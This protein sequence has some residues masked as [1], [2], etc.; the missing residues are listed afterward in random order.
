MLFQLLLSSHPEEVVHEGQ[1][2]DLATRRVD[3]A[4]DGRHDLMKDVRRHELLRHGVVAVICIGFR[5]ADVQGPDAPH[6]LG[7]DS[8]RRHLRRPL[9]RVNLG[10]LGGDDETRGAVELVVRHLGIPCSELIHDIVV[11]VHPERVEQQQ[12]DVQ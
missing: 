12:A 10:D 2:L 4:E 7:R 1:P 11:L 5:V 3:D 8:I 9:D 6:D